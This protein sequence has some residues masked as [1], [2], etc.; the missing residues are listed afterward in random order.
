MVKYPGVRANLKVWNN[1]T[2]SFTSKNKYRGRELKTDDFTDN[3]R[4]F[5]SDGDR[6]LVDHIPVL[7][8]KL[9][10]L[11]AIMLRLNG[12]RFYGC[13]ILLIYD[14]DQQ[15]QEQYAKG[16]RGM[17][18]PV[19]KG[20]R[21]RSADTRSRIEPIAISLSQSQSQ[22]P[23]RSS[24]RHSHSRHDSQHNSPHTHRSRLRGEINLRVVDFAHTTTGRDFVPLPAELDSKDMGKGYDTKFDPVSGLAMARFPP[25][26]L[27]KPDVGFIFGLRSLVRALKEIWAEEQDRRRAEGEEVMRETGV[28][29][30]DD[31]FTRAFGDDFD[32]GA[33][34]T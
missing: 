3:L 8:Q 5:I 20:R 24:R 29:R 23:G 14:G 13:S 4:T 32:T 25:K 11:A 26:H 6:L 1:E 34:S 28:I 10:D 18:E 22:I 16:M 21:S 9:H 30:E 27:Q 7:L 2:Q 12:F 33:L 15:V 31:V 17:E 19:G